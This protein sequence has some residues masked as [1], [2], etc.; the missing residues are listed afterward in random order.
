MK[1]KTVHFTN[2]L[3]FSFYSQRRNYLR[4]D[5]IPTFLQSTDNFF[6]I[7]QVQVRIRMNSKFVYTKKKKKKYLRWRN[8][9]NVCATS[10]M[11]ALSKCY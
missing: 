6:T 4:Y 3:Q 1:S 5:F 10:I 11:F 2:L 8:I 7:S 9:N